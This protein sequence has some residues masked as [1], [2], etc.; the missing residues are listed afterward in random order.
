M[1][2]KKIGI[3]RIVL[4]LPWPPT[5]NTYWRHS[6]GRHYISARGLSYRKDVDVKARIFAGLF[7]KEVKLSVH[8]D[9]FPPDRRR[10]DLDN[11]SKCLLD[12]L[13]HAGV[14]EDDYQIDELSLKRQ[15]LKDGKVIVYINKLS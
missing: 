2:D 4:H 6:R 15:E 1:C 11:I 13:Q 9:A 5:V 12:S 8:V 14:Y 10:R 3:D 7:P